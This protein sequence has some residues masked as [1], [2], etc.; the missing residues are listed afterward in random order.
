[1]VA[2]AQLV[3]RELEAAAGAGREFL[4][5]R[6]QKRGSHMF[7]ALRRLVPLLNA[8]LGA[9]T[10]LTPLWAQAQSQTRP[11]IRGHPR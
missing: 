10:L 6:K 3:R 2:G 4:T 1:M 7:T 5:N 11:G 8:A 9:V